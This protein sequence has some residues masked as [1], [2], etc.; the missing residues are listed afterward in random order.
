MTGL[1]VALILL[2]ETPCRECLILALLASGA[3]RKSRLLR[4]TA[5]C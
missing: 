4:G 2:Y 3:D 5:A 1:I